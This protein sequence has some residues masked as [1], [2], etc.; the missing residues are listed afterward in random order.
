MNIKINRNSKTPIYLQIKNGIRNLITTEELFPGFKM[1]SERKLAEEL[2]VHRNTVIKA[3]SEL[4][5]EGYITVSRVAPKGY[6]VVDAEKDKGFTGRFFPLG[7]RLRYNF[8]QNERLFFNLYDLSMEDNDYIS[9]G[10][11]TVSVLNEEKEEFCNIMSNVC[12]NSSNDEALRLKK[13]ICH[14]LEK[15]NI[16]V[17]E[18]N[19][20]ISTETNQ[21][22][23]QICDLFLSEGDIVVAEE[24]IVSDN[25]ALFRNKGIELVTIPLEEDGM[26]MKILE[27]VVSKKR[28]KFIY[29]LPTDRKSVV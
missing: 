2:D 6:F 9:M 8:T 1:P 13:N 5:A 15:E 14:L 17:N 22:L 4:V 24:P 28:P 21:L 27:N 29:T 26:N 3:Y 23:N 12:Y 7:K 10:G 18:K 25:I 11:L 19:I 16:Y 20:Q